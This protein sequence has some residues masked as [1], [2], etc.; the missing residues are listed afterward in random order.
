MIGA[1][2]QMGI[3]S[4]ISQTTATGASVAAAATTATAWAPAEAAVS[5]ASYGANAVPAAA[6]ITAVHSLSTGLAGARLYGGYTAPN[7]MYKVNENGKAEM[8]S[9]GKND[10]LMTGGSGGKVTSASDLGG[11]Q[12][13]INITTVNNASGTDVQVQQS[14]ANGQTDI[15]FIIDTVAGN[16]ASGGKVR[17]AITRSTSAKNKVV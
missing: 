13:V 12:P 6:G 17:T 16:I 8:F 2:I 9:D 4:L 3:Q 11:S 1:L 7:S 10:F 5:L 14:T 15:K